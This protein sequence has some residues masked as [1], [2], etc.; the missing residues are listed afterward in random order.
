MSFESLPKDVFCYLLQYVND[1]NN[2]KFLLNLLYVS[3]AFFNAIKAYYN[4]NMLDL[5]HEYLPTRAP[6]FKKIKKIRFE[7][8]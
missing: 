8:Y 4:S 3:K 1:I 6:I 7:I 5:S 2:T